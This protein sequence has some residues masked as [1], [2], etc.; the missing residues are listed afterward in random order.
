MMSE[1]QMMQLVV[2]QLGASSKSR[3]PMMETCTRHTGRRGDGEIV[4]RQ[5]RFR[6]H[7]TQR[8]KKY[9]RRT[10]RALSPRSNNQDHCYVPC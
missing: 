9:V 8:C 3:N 6:D 4:C 10:G 5:A 1:I 2:G 7:G